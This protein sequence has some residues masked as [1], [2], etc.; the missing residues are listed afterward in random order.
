MYKLD[1]ISKL[2]NENSAEMVTMNRVEFLLQTNKEC[3][4]RAYIMKIPV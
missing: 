3:L 4:Q 2:V 1:L